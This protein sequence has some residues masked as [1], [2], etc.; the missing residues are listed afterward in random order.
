[1]THDRKALED[2]IARIEAYDER[3]T[4]VFVGQGCATPE[5]ITDHRT[6]I[7][8]ARAQ[9]AVV[10]DGGLADDYETLR[11]EMEATAGELLDEKD[12]EIETLRAALRANSGAARE[13]VALPAVSLCGFPRAELEQVA[14]NLEAEP[15]RIG[16][17]NVTGMG[18]EFV[19]T[20]AAEAARFIRTVLQSDSGAVVEIPREAAL[21]QVILWALGEVGEFPDW[22]ETVTIKGNPKYWWRKELRKRYDAATKASRAEEKQSAKGE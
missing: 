13:P 17:G 19:P 18:D 7:A 8:A 12:R 22:P 9:L 20:A 14:E 1:M 3:M 11:K 2:A 5:G 15:Q 6:I 16:V 10:G 4:A 21:E